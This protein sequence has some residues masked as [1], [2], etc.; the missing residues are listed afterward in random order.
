[1]NELNSAQIYENFR[2]P[3]KAFIGK[4]VSN[5]EAAEDLVHDTFL[6]IHSSLATLKDDQSLTAWIYQV[7]RNVLIDF[8]RKKKMDHP[9]QIQEDTLLSEPE[10]LSDAAERLTPAL[11]L[12]IKRLPDKYRDALQLSD[13]EGKKHADIAELYGISVS[14]VKS[15]VQRA[16]AMLKQMLLE[17][18]HFEFDRYGTLF[19]YEPRKCNCCE[20]KP[21]GPSC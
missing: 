12:M 7:A 17:C 14:G 2:A 9:E 21:C 10:Q 6:K 16:R 19:E 20:Q 11:H 3:L 18:C 13:I 1:M 4:R 8:Y 15:R 5:P